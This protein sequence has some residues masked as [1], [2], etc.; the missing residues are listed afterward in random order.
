MKTVCSPLQN[1]SRLAHSLVLLLQ[2]SILCLK[3]K[4]AVYLFY[5][6]E[7]KLGNNFSL[8]ECY[9]IVHLNLKIK[10]IYSLFI[11]NYFIYLLIF[12]CVGSLLLCGMWN[13]PRSGTEPMSPALAGRFFTTEEVLIYI[14]VYI[15]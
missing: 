4:W 5:I 6:L 7:F 12:D 10:L 9:K 2:R 15:L 13:L 3:K 1:Q 14:L 8:I 11:F